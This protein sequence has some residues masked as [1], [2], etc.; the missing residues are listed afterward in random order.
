[1]KFQDYYEVL[2]VERDATPERIKKAYRKLALKWHPDKHQGDEREEAEARFKQASEAYEVLSDPEKR[3]RYDRFGEDWEHGQEFDPGP[4][5]RTM[6][7]EEFERTFGGAGG[8]SDFFQEVFGDQFR[9]DFGGRPGRHGRYRFRGAD[10]RAELS[11]PVSE[12]LRGGKRSFQIA[13]QATCPTCGGTGH[14]QRHVCPTCAGLGQVPHAKTVELTIPREARDGLT[15]R[16]EGLGEAGHDGGEAGDLFLT[17]RLEDDARLRVQGDDLESDVTVTPWQA[18]LGGQ[19]DV[20]TAVGVATVK[21]P[22]GSRSG[23]RLR[24]GGQGLPKKGGGRGDLYVRLLLDLPREL[25][26]EQRELLRSLARTTAGEAGG[27]S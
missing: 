3:A 25:T 21:V 17:L 11:L 1:V 26:E 14:V 23:R 10:V 19:V 20:R 8:F 16:L 13:A 7:R 12:A 9:G 22:A 18:E 5:R 27:V 2:G 24:L 4:E 6:S 15:L